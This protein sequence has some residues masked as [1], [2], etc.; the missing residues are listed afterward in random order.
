MVDD[1]TTFKENVK[2]RVDIVEVIGEFVEL[3][4]RGVNYIGPCPF[5]NET[6]PSFNVN[7]ERQF[8]H[9]FGCNK[10]GDVFSFLMD[11]T[12][13]SF[14]EA[15]KQLADRAG[16]KVPETRFTGREGAEKADAVIAANTAAAEYYHHTLYEAAGEPGM[17][18][19]LGRGLSKETIRVFRLGYAPPELSGLLAFARGKS[20]GEEALDAAGIIKKSSYSGAPFNRF[21]G[22]VIFPIIDQTAR[23]IG[24]GAR[25]LEGEG[26]KYV[27]SAESPVYHKSTVLFGIYQARA[28]IKRTRTAV[29][30]EGYMDVI[31]LHQAGIKNVIAASGTAFTVEQ[32]RQI[33]RLSRN[34]TLLFDGDS[35]GM[36]AAARGADN[37]LATDLAIGVVVLPGGHDPDSYVREQGA[38]VL[39]ELLK[40]PM[41]I[42]EFKLKALGGNITETEDRIKLSGE[43][44][45]SIS[46]IA[47]EIKRDVYI[48]DLSH[49]LGIDI[50]A[51]DK[52]VRGRIR[53]R[54]TPRAEGGGERG[55]TCPPGECELLASIVQYPV[56]A[57]NFMEEAGAKAF[58]HPV[59][60]KIAEVVFHRIV[61]GLDISPSSLM[62]V[63]SDRT[64]QELIAAAGMFQLDEEAAG[65]LIDGGL[66]QH[67]VRELSDE[68]A[69]ISRKIMQESDMEK[70]SALV[71]KQRD[72]FERLQKYTKG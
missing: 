39:G 64:A 41:D 34:V 43:I 57:R 45:D 23:I 56:L 14:M 16:L 28:E 3:K 33:N 67:V 29:V 13:M 63:I 55:E 32:G 7:R 72:T 38:E 53:R 69:D 9:C 51:M 40:N 50:N 6:K 27:N 25:I 5:H 1:F 71:K 37:L 22:R 66:R 36:T 17:T 46:L 26:A 59:M 42:W 54:R 30:V 11:I 65:R 52:A 2:S 47:D 61:E 48:R 20:V 15:L 31:S 62:N 8:Y 35:A 4:K 10:G 44:A 60:K 21:G 58:T 24:F 19:L 68:I 70:K 49:K 12:G 18:Y